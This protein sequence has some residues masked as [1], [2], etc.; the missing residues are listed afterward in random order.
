[1]KRIA[2]ILALSLILA[3]LILGSLSQAPTSAQN[4]QPSSKISSLLLIQV[5]TK[6][7]LANSELPAEMASIPGLSQNSQQ[8]PKALTGLSTQRIFIYLTEPPGQPQI[9]E[10]E[11]LGLSLYLDSWIPPVGSHPQGFIIADMPIDKLEKL[12][13]KDFVVRLNSAERLAQPQNDLVAIVTNADDV[14]SLGYDGTG[15]RI[16]VLD[17][18][19]DINHPD[20]PT[21]IASKD[22]SNY[23]DYLD[24]TIANTVTGHGTHVV[25]SAV[26]RGTQS[27]GQYQG[28]APGADLIFLKIGNDTHGNASTAAIVGALEAAVDIYN[29]DIITMSYGGWDTYH[30][31]TSQEAQAVDYAF[32]QGAVVFISA[33]NEA[34]NDEHYSDTIAATSTTDFIQVNVSGSP[35]SLL[36]FNLAWYDGLGTH[37]ELELHYFDSSFNE[38]T[39]INAGAQSESPRGTEAVVA[40]ALLNESPYYLKVENKSA[41]SQLFH[42]Y[43]IPLIGSASFE[44]AD[45]FYTITSPANADNAIAVG[46]YTTRDSWTNYRGNSYN[47]GETVGSV[48]SY[49]SRGPRVDT[50][51][52]QKPNIVAPGSAIISCR[53]TDVYTWPNADYDSLII[54]NDGLNLN[55]SGPADYFVMQGTSMAS[56]TAAGA[57]ALLLEADPE[58]KGNPAAVRDRLHQAASQAGSPDNIW[59]YGLV[60]SYKAI[61]DEVVRKG[62]FTGDGHIDIFDFVQFAD[63]YGSELG[64]L[65]YN[66]IG[67]FDDDGD[68]DIFDFVDFADVYGT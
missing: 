39:N 32:N 51:A 20:I 5:E 25:G 7:R 10:L 53:D 41:S 62:D 43:V 35:Y 28:I 8:P 37:N 47:I 31:G 44:D 55:G 66:A 17:S 68:I 64:D 19:L 4:P 52:Q 58:L 49:S 56:P 18:G 26:G 59:G 54:D 21:P 38:L 65:N 63:A 3:I 11:A 14:W 22:Y 61:G 45:P 16:A 42:I 50:G 33:G 29:A 23:P 34:S 60:D 48:T 36:Y 57:A 2:K 27:A 30:D 6:Q 12:A 1:M 67:D 24:D 46:A 40:L 15:V 13:S 9:E